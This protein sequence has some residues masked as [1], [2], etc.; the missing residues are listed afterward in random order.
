M[1]AAVGPIDIESLPWQSLGEHGLKRKVLSHDPDT[2]EV[3]QYVHIPAKWK[4]GGVAHFHSCFEEALI[5]EGDVTLNGGRDRLV[6][7]SYLYRPSKIVHGHDEGATQGCHCIIRMGAEM[8]FNLVHEPKSEEEYPLEPITD[9]RGHV[10]H[11]KT[12]EMEWTEQGDEDNRY[13]FKLLSMDPATKAYTAL[14]A[15]EP[16]W[17]GRLSTDSKYGREWLLLSGSQQRE[18]GST[19]GTNTYYYAPPG[20]SHA[21]MTGSED[22]CV[23]LTWMHAES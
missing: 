18:D 9:P 1:K 15:L 7:G 22:G 17:S 2:G 10:L 13:R 11:L 21:A 14:L 4:G 19:F 5:I 16:G 6:D 12:P 3:T 20:T 8:D 23:V